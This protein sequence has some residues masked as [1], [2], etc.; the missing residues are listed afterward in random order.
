[1]NEAII[2]VGSV[3]LVIGLVVAIYANYQEKK[4]KDKN[5]AN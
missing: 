1:M 4:Q 3:F 5:K 2:T